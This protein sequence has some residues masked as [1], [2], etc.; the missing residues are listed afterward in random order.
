MAQSHYGLGI[1]RRCLEALC[2]DLERFCIRL[3]QI[4]VKL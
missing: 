3:P 4:D 2:C 1:K